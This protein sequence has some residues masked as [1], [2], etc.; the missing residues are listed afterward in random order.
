[1]ALWVVQVVENSVMLTYFETL[2]VETVTP[3][4]CG[5]GDLALLPDVTDFA[6]KQASPWDRLTT[7][8]GDFVRLAAPAALV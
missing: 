2:L 7:P 6:A 1:M 3:K 8:D 5:S 4:P